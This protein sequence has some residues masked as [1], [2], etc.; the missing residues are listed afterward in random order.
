MDHIDDRLGKVRLS[1]LAGEFAVAPFIG[2]LALVAKF[3]GLHLL[4]FPEMGA[5]SYDIL[6]RPHGTWARSPIMLALTP[7][8]AAIL[9]TVITRE[10]AYGP[11]AVLLAIG[12]AMA[13]IRLLRSPIAPALAV[14]QIARA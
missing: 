11:V 8:L 6:N 9:G 4:L 10:L 14:A 12:G 5:L 3:S 2:A 1:W 13:I 7:F